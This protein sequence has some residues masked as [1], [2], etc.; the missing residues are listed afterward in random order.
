MQ[1]YQAAKRYRCPG[2]HGDIEPGTGHRRGRPRAADR[3][4]W[5]LPWRHRHRASL[6]P[7]GSE[8]A[9]SMTPG[10][11]RPAPRRPRRSARPARTARRRP[12][13]R[14]PA[15]AAGPAWSASPPRHGYPNASVD[16]LFTSQNTTSAGAAH[17]EVELTV[18]A[19]ASCGPAPR[20]R[21]LSYQRAT[22]SSP[23]APR[24]RVRPVAPCSRHRA[25]H[26]SGRGSSSTLTSLNVTHP[27][28]GARTGCGGTCPTPTRRAGGPRPWARPPS[29]T[30]LQLDVV[31]QV[32]AA[33]GL[34]GVAEHARPR[35]GTPGPAAALASASKFSR[36]SVLTR[37]APVLG[38]PGRRHGRQIGRALL[39]DLGRLPGAIPQVVELGPA[40]VAPR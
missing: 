31:G 18:A 16:R 13:T 24:A 9:T 19:R 39:A 14:R 1:P 6:D 28:A 26:S 23:K 11:T 33:L 30:T 20:S 22:S 15:A 7:G 25:A 32:E 21:R 2:C 3:R 34:H 17:D 35:P 8:R 12:A 5:H 29:S 10:D 36:S 38:E 27:H 4:H 37:S 40:H